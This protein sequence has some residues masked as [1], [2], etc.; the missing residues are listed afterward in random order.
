M[1]TTPSYAEG[2][3]RKREWYARNGYLDRVITSEDAPD[4]SIDAA[5]I[6]RNARDRIL[7][8]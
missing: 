4:G 3:T 6:A 5:V 7:G 8:E 1:L 2:W